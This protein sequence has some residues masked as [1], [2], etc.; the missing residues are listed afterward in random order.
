MFKILKLY[1]TNRSYYNQRKRYKK[2]Q[3]EYRKKLM[4]QAKEFCPWSG[5]YMHAMMKTMLEFYYKTYEAGNC[6]WSVEE[7]IKKIAAQ[8]KKALDYAHDLDTYEDLGEE[9]LL[10]IAEKEYGFK[11]YV[12]KWEK[13]T[14]TKANS[15]LM[16]GIAFDYYEKKYT[17][18]LYNI[19]GK[20]IWEW[21]D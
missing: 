1:F 11:K 19:I 2:L 5:W 21:C 13:K 6:C 16:Y 12:E 14:G 18:A 7:R 3:K 8:T 9:E 20:H 4:K 15:K 10:A 17:E